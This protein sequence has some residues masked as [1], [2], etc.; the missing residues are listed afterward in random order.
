MQAAEHPELSAAGGGKSLVENFLAENELTKDY[1]ATANMLYAA[2]NMVQ[3]STFIV[4]GK[5]DFF[6]LKEVTYLLRNPEDTAALSEAIAD[7]VEAAFN[8]DRHDLG[9]LIKTAAAG[10]TSLS[11][12]PVS[13]KLSG[14]AA[15]IDTLMGVIETAMKMRAEALAKLSADDRKAIEAMRKDFT[16]TDTGFDML[17]ALRAISKIDFRKL[18]AA[19]AY[20]AQVADQFEALQKCGEAFRGK[21]A[22][23]VPG[24]TGEVLLFKHTKYGDII[25]GGAG[26][27]VYTADAAIIID[28]G[29]NDVY[30]NNAGGTFGETYFALCADFGGDDVYIGKRSIQQGA[31]MLGCGILIDTEGDDTYR[32]GYFSQGYGLM[33]V[34]LLVDLSGERHVPR[35]QSRAGRGVVR[36]RRAGRGRGAGL[37]P[38]GQLRAGSGPVQGLRGGGRDER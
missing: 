2:S 36:H 30:R 27:N 37:V 34:G 25:V 24:V 9:G 18:Y 7:S 15:D 14:N 16:E 29:G 33:G 10:W 26:D 1:L 28:I 35:A 20:F 38:R 23:K 21:S 19:C 4:E 8:K 13:P 6:R 17:A 5:P 12:P 3:G 22:G 32:A 11:S 31:A